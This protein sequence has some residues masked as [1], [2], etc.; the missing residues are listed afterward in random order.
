MSLGVLVSVY[1]ETLT[2]N[3][4]NTCAYIYIYVYTYGSFSRL[5]YP[6][7]DPNILESL[8]WGPPKRYP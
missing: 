2:V 3:S 1:F 5:G 7:I 6:N 4:T 8:L